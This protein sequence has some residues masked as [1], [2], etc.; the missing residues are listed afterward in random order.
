MD[1]SENSTRSTFSSEGGSFNTLNLTKFQWYNSIIS[2]LS[3]LERIKGDALAQ[4]TM[5]T[6]AKFRKLLENEKRAHA[7][8]LAKL[9]NQ[10]VHNRNQSVHA[11]QQARLEAAGFRIPKSKVR[12][13]DLKWTSFT[14]V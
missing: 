6:E 8:A 9:R 11:L 4:A 3:D 7:T 1:T 13:N 10:M 12:E 14:F 2:T 5:A